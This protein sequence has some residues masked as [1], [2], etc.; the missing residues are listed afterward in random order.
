M[1]PGTESALGP[2]QSVCCPLQAI[3]AVRQKIPRG[4]VDRVARFMVVGAEQVAQR[5]IVGDR[6]IGGPRRDWHLQ[7]LMEQRAYYDSLSRDLGLRRG[8]RPIG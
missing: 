6:Q 8:D 1:V 5:G 4:G 2:G 7:R 3:A